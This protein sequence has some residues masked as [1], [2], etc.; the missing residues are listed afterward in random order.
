MLRFYI[1][2]VKSLVVNVVLNNLWVS[3][4]VCSLV[5]ALMHVLV[6]KVLY[7]WYYWIESP[8]LFYC[9]NLSL[10]VM[11]VLVCQCALRFQHKVF[12]RESEA[13]SHTV[14][15]QSRSSFE[16]TFYFTELPYVPV[17]TIPYIVRYLLYFCLVIIAITLFFCAILLCAQLSHHC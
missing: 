16:L 1:R 4:L 10:T 2:W 13:I 12:L 5:S 14:A 6:C 7:G 11:V 3:I 17:I 9:L 15:S 8:G